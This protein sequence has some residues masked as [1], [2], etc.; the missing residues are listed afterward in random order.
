MIAFLLIRGT[1]R[2]RADQNRTGGCWCEQQRLLSDR[3]LLLG[4]QQQVTAT[5]GIQEMKGPNKRKAPGVGLDP[6]LEGPPTMRGPPG[7][8]RSKGTRCSVSGGEQIYLGVRVRMPVRDLLKNI[9][10]PKDM[11]P[12]D[13]NERGSKKG[14]GNQKRARTRARKKVTRAQHPVKSLEELAII[15]EVLEEDL[16]S[17]CTPLTPNSPPSD[18]TTYPERSPTG[19]NSGDEYDE[20]IPSPESYMAFS[21]SASAHNLAWTRPDCMFLSLQPSGVTDAQSYGGRGEGWFEPKNSWDLN[22]SAFFWTQLQKEES[23][24]RKTSDAELLTTDKHSRTLLHKVVCLGKRAQAYAIA[25]RMSAINSLD[26]KDSDGMTALLYAAKHNQHLMVADLIQLGANV[27]ETNNLGKSCLHLSAE[28]GYIR[29]LEVLKQG[30]MDGLYIDVEA[31][32]NAGMSVL[33]C[34]AVALKASISEVDSGMSLSHSRLHALRQEHMMETLKCVLQ[35][36]SFL[37]AAASWSAAD[38]EYTVQSWLGSQHVCPAGHF[39]TPTVM[40]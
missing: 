4:T 20:I 25:K 8:K 14:S 17:G 2:S 27:N 6:P 9:R 22:T 13:F 1:H 31:T 7:C 28:N 12:D 35:M 26:L 23:R 33:Q 10:V 39:G 36:D 5:P 16:R 21:P 19:V 15:V 24:L 32:D 11:N 40:F 37:H 18:S 29:V 30:M 38:P 3:Q 34:A